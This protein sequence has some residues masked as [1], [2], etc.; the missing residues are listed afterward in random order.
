M[1]TYATVLYEVKDHIA[2]V[3]MNRPAALNAYNR[4]ML[5]ELEKVWEEVKR[6]SDVHVAILTGSGEKAFSSGAD[7]EMRRNSR[8]ANGLW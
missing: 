3:T 1:V 5:I 4:Q 6:D 8:R 2:Y 7:I